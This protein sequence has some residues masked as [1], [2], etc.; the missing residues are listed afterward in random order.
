MKGS[1]SRTVFLFLGFLLIVF[2][3]VGLV[4]VKNPG[5]FFR[6]DRY[7]LTL[8]HFCAF[9]EAVWLPS[10]IIGFPMFLISLIVSLV[11]DRK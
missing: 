7:D 9:C 5:Y 10:G 8:E 2:F 1:K 11:R 4:S 6:K 3:V